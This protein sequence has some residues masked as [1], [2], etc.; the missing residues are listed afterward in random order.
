MTHPHVRRAAAARPGASLILSLALVFISLAGS[1]AA[2]PPARGVKRSTLA[3]T[4]P[5]T[6]SPAAQTRGAMRATGAMGA[7][8]RL[9]L[10]IVVD[11]FRADYLERFGDLFATKADCAA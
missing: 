2:Q 3:T 9:V 10:V 1:T 7:R 11:Q 5:T 8:S 4:P 6:L